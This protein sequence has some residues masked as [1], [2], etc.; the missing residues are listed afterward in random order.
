MGGVRRS[1]GCTRSTCCTGWASARCR[2][3]SATLVRLTGRTGCDDHGVAVLAGRDG[4]IASVEAGWA[5]PPGGAGFAFELT[6]EAASVDLLGGAASALRRRGTA[7]AG[8]R[9]GGADPRPGAVPGYPARR[10]AGAADRAGRCAGGDPPDRR[11]LS[12]LSARRSGPGRGYRA[13]TSAASSTRPSST[14]TGAGVS[15]SPAQGPATQRPSATRNRAPVG[16]AG[17]VFPVRRHEPVGHPVQRRAGM[18]AGIEIAVEPV[19]VARDQHVDRPALPVAQGEAAGPPRPEST[20]PDRA[21]V[22]ATAAGQVTGAPSSPHI[23][24][25]CGFPVREG[26]R[27]GGGLTAGG[28]GRR[29]RCA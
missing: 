23:S 21:G 9:R 25:A 5:A 8:R 7:A 6:T 22:P 29:V 28:L 18:G 19:A 13:A 17:K 27:D 1:W 24:R 10:S 20:R 16:R 15:R 12:P 14:R 26:V 4:L 2:L 3:R 11:G